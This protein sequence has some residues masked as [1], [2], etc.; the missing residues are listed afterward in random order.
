M[1][2]AISTSQEQDQEFQVPKMKKLTISPLNVDPN[3]L[4]PRKKSVFYTA[5]MFSEK[6]NFGITEDIA[7]SRKN[8]HHQDN[9]LEESKSMGSSKSDFRYKFISIMLL[10]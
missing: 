2:K 7:E 6:G 3:N 4:S 9:I 8:L 10:F 5:K 1:R